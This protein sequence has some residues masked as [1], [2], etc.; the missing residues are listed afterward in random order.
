[1][2]K[3][4]WSLF[5]GCSLLCL[6]PSTGQ[7]AQRTYAGNLN[8]ILETLEKEQFRN[9]SEARYFDSTTGKF[10]QPILD[11]ISQDLNDLNDQHLSPQGQKLFPLACE[12]SYARGS[13]II[14]LPSTDT[15]QIEAN[16]VNGYFDLS[17][18]TGLP[19]L[20]QISK[21]YG[22][23][24]LRLISSSR[25][26]KRFF[27]FHFK[28]TS[29]SHLFIMH[30]LGGNFPVHRPIDKPR[31]LRSRH[32][33]MRLEALFFR[34]EIIYRISYF[35]LAEEGSGESNVRQIR[36]FRSDFSSTQSLSMA[37]GHDFI[38]PSNSQAELVF[39]T[40]V[41]NSPVQ[42][43]AMP[44]PG[45]PEH[46]TFSKLS[47][48]LQ[49]AADFPTKELFDNYLSRI[50]TLFSSTLSLDERRDFGSQLWTA[51]ETLLSRSLA[52]GQSLILKI[53]EDK[54]PSLG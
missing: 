46:Q 34:N 31:S 16:L 30:K 11:K 40:T 49:L 52:L 13:L 26:G 54:P 5:L 32:N 33:G 14:T 25:D 12:E 15:Q 19:I 53:T 29:S 45:T 48:C 4:F 50:F 39:N 27:S 8:C 18:P 3:I 2:K 23:I 44:K 7:S 28:E 36:Y 22:G 24:H 17:N 41:S 1:M 35:K 43:L 20:D 51:R 47:P 42:L 37:G 6:L 10:H 38:T 9:F 21:E